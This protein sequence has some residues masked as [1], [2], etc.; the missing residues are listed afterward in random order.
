MKKVLFFALLYV[1][2]AFS[3]GCKHE[4]PT[5]ETSD[6][7][8]KDLLSELEIA[9]KNT[10][11]ESA[12]QASAIKDLNAAVPQTGQ[13]GGAQRK[14][15]LSQSQWDVYRQQEKYFEVKLEERRIY[16]RK[17]YLESLLPNG[18][19]WPAPEEDAEYALKL[20]LRRAKL[21]WDKKRV[22]RGTASAE[23]QSK[24]KTE[25]SH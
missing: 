25:S 13:R 14:V 3:S 12:Q 6:S 2:A 24:P 8:F 15:F 9:K 11:E 16:V 1:F 17:R 5:P 23:K 20:K 10:L 19:P 18:R 21:D 4:D 7:I 22:P